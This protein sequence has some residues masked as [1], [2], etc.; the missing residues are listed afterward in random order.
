M[1][2]KGFWIPLLLLS[3]NRCPISWCH[4]SIGITLDAYR[5]MYLTF[6][7]ERHYTN[8]KVIDYIPWLRQQLENEENSIL[9]GLLMD[10]TLNQ[11][12]WAGLPWLQSNSIQLWL[13][14]YRKHKQSQSW[15][16]N[17]L[18]ICQLRRL[19]RNTKEVDEPFILASQA[20]QIFYCK[21]QSWCMDDWHAVLDWTRTWIIMKIH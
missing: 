14:A 17:E 18:G 15:T 20:T 12:N 21:D 2:P 13:G 16:R 10:Q 5:V 6:K 7:S 4:S 9:K 8:I 19:K 1:C 3:R 11:S